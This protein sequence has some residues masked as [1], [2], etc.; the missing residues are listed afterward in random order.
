M[1]VR[2]DSRLQPDPGGAVVE[3][4]YT[5]QLTDYVA[6]LKRRSRLM[7]NVAV[8]I[9]L[10]AVI[11]ATALPEVYQS[12]A[13]IDI[14]ETKIPGYTESQGRDQS[15][16]DQYVAG[17]SDEVL[18]H[19]GMLAIVRKFNPYPDVSDEA[20]AAGKARG[21]VDVEMITVQVLDTYSGRQ[22]KLITAFSVGFEN[23]NPE[24]A[25]KVAA[26]LADAYLTVDRQRRE[27]RASGSVAFLA[28][29]AGRVREEIAA[30]EARLGVQTAQ[31]RATSGSRQ[32]EPDRDGSHP[33]RPRGRA[34]PDAHVAAG[35]DFPRAAARAGAAGQSGLGIVGAASGRVHPQGR[36]V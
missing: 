10:G 25:Q 18:K 15:F 7:I 29:E 11:L 24:T 33:A 30:L 26:W 12:S 34:A 16:A 2:D 6:A 36:T 9:V 17:L 27:R 23:R 32:H 1:T 21:D 4:E 8:P 31:C 3:T 35:Q 5:P 14:E 22:R 19:E 28:G 20:E 13:V